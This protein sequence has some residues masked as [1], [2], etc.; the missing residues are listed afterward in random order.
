MKWVWSYR[1]RTVSSQAVKVC[2]VSLTAISHFLQTEE[3]FTVYT[4]ILL[5]IYTWYMHT[6]Y[7]VCMYNIATMMWQSRGL[8]WFP[9]GV[10][11]GEGANSH[12]V[13][14]A[15]APR[16]L[17]HLSTVRHDPIPAH[18]DIRDGPCT[19][20][21]RHLLRE[22]SHGSLWLWSQ[23]RSCRCSGE[24]CEKLT[25]TAV[26]AHIT[27]DTVQFL[28]HALAYCIRQNIFLHE[29]IKHISMF[30]LPLSHF[31]CECRLTFSLWHRWAALG[32][33]LW[34]ATAGPSSLQSQ[35]K[36][37]LVVVRQHGTVLVPW[38]YWVWC[39]CVCVC[40]CVYVL[41]TS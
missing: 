18:Q 37:S 34:T 7:T 10:H 2:S 16:Y 19:K 41:S 17:A 39:E 36:H 40:L 11:E 25:S 27:W 33:S 28:I 22:E 3:V 8:L 4:C 30:P 21:P 35:S 23:R 38:C 5:Y 6:L 9:Y 32:G 14:G 1:L 20:F 24:E 13:C 15:L 31:L 26:N 12:R 29:Q